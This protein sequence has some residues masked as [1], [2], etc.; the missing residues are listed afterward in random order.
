MT[1]VLLSPNQA[2]T[3]RER[4]ALASSGCRRGKR[5]ERGGSCGAGQSE[6]T[7]ERGM[8]T[9]SPGSSA[10]S[11]PVP[12]Y[13]TPARGVVP[14]AGWWTFGVSTRRG[15][16]PFHCERSGLGAGRASCSPGRP[17]KVATPGRAEVTKRWRQPAP[18]PAPCAH[19][20]RLGNAARHGRCGSRARASLALLGSPCTAAAFCRTSIWV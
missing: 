3:H 17:D 6:D 10:Q 20:G 5:N 8:E 18:L 2:R 4:P 7:A 19:T 11:L 1:A 12:P 14:G 9:R 13:P 16:S 15:D